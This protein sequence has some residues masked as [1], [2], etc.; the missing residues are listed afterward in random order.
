MRARRSPGEAVDAKISRD[1]VD[2]AVT[3]CYAP[4]FCGKRP[5]EA[6]AAP[7]RGESRWPFCQDRK[8]EKRAEENERQLIAARLAGSNIV[9]NKIGGTQN[10]STPKHA[11]GACHRQSDRRA[12]SMSGV[13]A[14]ESDLATLDENIKGASNAGLERELAIRN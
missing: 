3:S 10:A 1:R 14:R 8:P 7:W 11:S 13:P 2:A 5:P 4:L 9:R 12:E 6:V